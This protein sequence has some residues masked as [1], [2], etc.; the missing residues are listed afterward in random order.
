LLRETVL[1]SG[2]F[3]LPAMPAPAPSL[4]PGWRTVLWKT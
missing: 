3:E 1:V 2:C 4:P